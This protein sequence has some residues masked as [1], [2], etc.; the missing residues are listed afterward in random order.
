MKVEW[1]GVWTQCALILS[2][3]VLRVNETIMYKTCEFCLCKGNHFFPYILHGIII[4]L[5]I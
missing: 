5:M 4:K 2:D 3:V 1:C